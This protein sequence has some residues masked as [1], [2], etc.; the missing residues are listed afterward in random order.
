MMNR[1][2]SRDNKISFSLAHSNG[3]RLRTVALPIEHGG[4]GLALEPVALGLLVA[5]SLAGAGLALATLGAFLARHPLK[6]LAS[7]RRNNR[8]FPRT[9]IAKRFVLLYGATAALG[10]LIALMAA[11][12]KQ[13]LWPLLLAAPLVVVQLV[14]DA[15][16][17]S[18]A[19]WPELAGSTAMAAVATSIALADGW[20]WPV[21]FGL[22]AVL[23]ARVVPTILYV[24]AR[25]ARLHGKEVV[26]IPVMTA[27]LAALAFIL[28]LAWLNVVPL[29]ASG[30][31]IV[32]ML[33]A[34]VGFSTGRPGT[35]KAIGV[36]EL[37]FGA[38]T[39]FAVALGHLISM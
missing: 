7:D 21:A 33:R 24:R 29:L 32:L 2:I 34:I 31:L 22:W 36:S 4:W 15:K 12:S 39:L 38:M 17:Q 10:L 6:L 5:P 20:A 28:L 30:A 35:A 26:I 8:R 3:M 23:A 18:R 16:G 19:L 9:E 1:L 11:T 13:F 25:L 14:A 27:H 37:A